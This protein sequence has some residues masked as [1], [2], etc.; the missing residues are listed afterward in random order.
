MSWFE[1]IKSSSAAR[2]VS[3]AAREIFNESTAEIEEHFEGGIVQKICGDR[4]T[5]LHNLFYEDGLRKELEQCRE[6]KYHEVA[7]LQD[8][9]A[10]RVARFQER[11]RHLEE[12]QSSDNTSRSP[13]SASPSL[14]HVN[15]QT[16][17]PQLITCKSQTSATAFP[18]SHENA[19]QTERKQQTPSADLLKEPVP[20]ID[21][22]IQTDN[23]LTEVEGVAKSET[24]GKMGASAVS[25]IRDDY[26]KEEEDHDEEDSEE[27]DSKAARFERI[28]EA[29]SSAVSLLPP[30]PSEHITAM[31]W[32]PPQPEVQVAVL[33]AAEAASR[34]ELMM[35]RDYVAQLLQRPPAHSDEVSQLLGAVLTSYSEL[36][37]GQCTL[38]DFEAV[39]KPLVERDQSYAE[40]IE[41][42]KVTPL[43]KSINEICSQL[44]ASGKAI[45]N[46]EAIHN[47][48]VARL[49]KL[50]SKEK[51]D[52]LRDFLTTGRGRVG[53]EDQKIVDKFN[54]LVKE[55]ECKNAICDSLLRLLEC[56]TVEPG[57]YNLD[58]DGAFIIKRVADA[59][60]VKIKDQNYD[61]TIEDIRNRIKSV[62][63]EKLS[64]EL[65]SALDYLNSLFHFTDDDKN[66]CDHVIANDLLKLLSLQPCSGKEKDSEHKLRDCLRELL[67]SNKLDSTDLGTED[68]DV[69][70]Q[71]VDKLNCKSNSVNS[72]SLADLLKTITEE[73]QRNN[74]DGLQERIKSAGLEEEVVKYLGSLVMGY[75]N[76]WSKYAQA[77]KD[78]VA[79]GQLVRSK[80]EESKAYHAQLQKLL[81]ERQSTGVNQL[82]E[83]AK[84]QAKIERLES[85][86]LQTEA[87][88][89]QEAVVAEE[90]E[91]SLRESLTRAEAKAGTLQEFVDAAEE[92]I[93]CAREER[94]AAREAARA[95]QN[96]LVALRANYN[97]LQKALDSLEKEKHA[98]T[99]ATAQHYRMENE[100]LQRELLELQQHISGLTTEVSRLGS[101]EANNHVL[102]EQLERHAG[103]LSEAQA[104]ARRYEERIQVLKGELK[105]KSEELENKLDKSIMK[106]LLISCMKLPLVKRPEAFRALGSVLNFTTEDYNMLGFNEPVATNWKELFWRPSTSNGQE[107]SKSEHSF[108]ELLANFLEK[109]S[110]PPAQIRLPTD[111]LRSN[112]VSK[113]EPGSEFASGAQGER[114]NSMPASQLRLPFL[115]GVNNKQEQ[116][117]AVLAPLPQQ[118][119]SPSKNPLLSG[120]STVKHPDDGN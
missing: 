19:V 10:A 111:Y 67:K 109:E 86:L 116:V 102:Q 118:R 53:Y 41:Q 15:T 39:A 49:Y 117:T 5:A 46:A 13:P 28:S 105:E 63:I 40:V 59:L 85:H 104:L 78:K 74:L 18:S 82:Q 103:R 92:R 87:N 7:T 98:E 95:C 107:S 51:S 97:N 37:Q 66:D 114:T 24:T 17:L 94:E 4:E 75:T 42:L 76:L 106:S 89:T 50:L 69:V 57:E 120:L 61:S 34:Q 2:L 47:P 30:P 6:E 25:N 33:V 58:S 44:E 8:A 99:N 56:G 22:I 20:S 88:H 108:V 52:P 1:S 110:A 100:R 48:T 119:P 112:S 65:K 62:D 83:V 55:A 70:K 101:L 12:L 72:A 115:S 45:K 80:H 26:E 35:T 79:L 23:L 81:A 73:M 9:V 43:E 71:L 77:E 91:A 21:A 29:L 54:F 32:P 3:S 96:E 11:L 27:M 16:E 90:R 84:L 14:I 31:V 60:A 36:L 93:E 64:P 113:M 38:S 68:H